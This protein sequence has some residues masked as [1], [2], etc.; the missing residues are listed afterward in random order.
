MNKSEELSDGLIRLEPLSFLKGKHFVV[1]EYQRGY[2]WGKK[3][4]VQLLEDIRAHDADKGIYCLQP[5]V[6]SENQT[7][8]FEIVDGQQRCTSIYLLLFFLLRGCRYF[9]IDYKTRPESLSFLSEKL[10]AFDKVDISDVSDPTDDLNDVAAIDELWL[11]FLNG[12]TNRDVDNADIYH[13][14]TVYTVIRKYFEHQRENYLEE[15]LKKLLNKVCFIWYNANTGEHKDISAIF[16]NINR[17]K[18]TL[19]SA[20]LIKALF[21][22]NIK[23]GNGTDQFKANRIANLAMEWDQI[24]NQLHDKEFWYFLCSDIFRYDKGTRIDLLFDLVKGRPD[25]NKDEY[26]AYLKYEQDFNRWADLD[27]LLVKQLFQRLVDWYND[28][29]TYHFVG[30]LITAKIE[31]LS[32]L[33]KQSYCRKDEF[34]SLLK[35]KI[36]KEFARRTRGDQSIQKYDLKNVDFQEDTLVVKRILLLFN[37]MYYVKNPG[38]H[39]FPFDMYVENAWSIEHINP[40]H[41]RQ[42]E[43]VNDYLDLVRE[44][45][46]DAQDLLEREAVEFMELHSG[47]S[48]SNLKKEEQAKIKRD[49]ERIVQAYDVHHLG[50]LTLLDRNTNSAV[51]NHRFGVKREKILAFDAQGIYLSDDG[52]EKLKKVYIPVTTK[53]VFS[54][55]Y[56]SDK[57]SLGSVSWTSLDQRTYLQEIE[58]QLKEFLPRNQQA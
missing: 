17:G 56:T 13:F 33:V 49:F 31:T 41:P 32:A 55:T 22:L 34:L 24:E 35:D 4:I 16:L 28:K 12:Q 23:R 38:I 6:I 1:E 25:K 43:D 37:V 52:S 11:G 46:S 39:K 8:C 47:R 2:K 53:N 3:E 51:S 9:T 15:F 57:S 19:T 21:I 27:W 14:F 45:I 26:Y 10:S 30:Y 29:Y 44:Y 40:Q 50:N 36:T 7:N 5:L 42:T 18:I 20:E 58:R 54:K 48:L